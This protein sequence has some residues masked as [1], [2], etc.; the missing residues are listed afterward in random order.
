MKRKALIFIFVF[1]GILV[2]AQTK[3]SSPSKK[4]ELYSDGFFISST[5]YN[6]SPI[7]HDVVG[8]ATSAYEKAQLIYLWLCSHISY[9]PTGEIRT[10]DECWQQRKGV[11]QGYC[12]LFYRMGETVGLKTKLIYGNGK[13]SADPSQLEKHVWLSVSTEKG[14]ILIDPTWGAGLFVNGKFQQQH[15]PL[16]WFDTDPNWFIFTHYPQKKKHQHIEK[17]ISEKEFLML[18][19]VN[20][21]ASKLGVTPREALNR[22]LSGEEVFPTIPILN[23]NYLDMVKLEEVPLCRHLKIGESYTFKVSKVQ[24]N[25]KLELDNEGSLREEGRWEKCGQCYTTTVS[26]K[27]AGKF[28]LVV[29][30]GNDFVPIKKNVL[31][32]VVE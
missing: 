2:W 32:Y 8:D 10:A 23:T 9:D 30:G 20:P 18:P 11:C 13:R 1:V 24:D 26:P 3:N 28:A 4:K 29:I 5:A 25:C 17:A 21:I 22:A 19:Y 27:K 16:I 12:E 31:E 7:A 6:Y 15:N 14:D